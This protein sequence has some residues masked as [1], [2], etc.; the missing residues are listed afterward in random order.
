MK[1]LEKPLIYKINERIWNDE[2]ISGQMLK[3]A[4]GSPD[5]DGASRRAEFY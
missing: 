4:P 5:F 3:S 2:Y 1:T